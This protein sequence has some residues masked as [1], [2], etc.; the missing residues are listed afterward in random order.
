MKQHVHILVAGLFILLLFK[1]VAVVVVEIQHHV[2]NEQA[3]LLLK[4]NTPRDQWGHDEGCQLMFNGYD[5]EWRGPTCKDDS[6]QD[7]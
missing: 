3:L 6:N 5:Y 4:N 1:V 7:K 2:A